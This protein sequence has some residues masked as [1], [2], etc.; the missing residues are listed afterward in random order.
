MHSFESSSLDFDLIVAATVDH[1]LV[2]FV[3]STPRPN[4]F[5]YSFCVA[6]HLN[7]PIVV[8]IARVVNAKEPVHLQVAVLHGAL[9]TD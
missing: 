3:F 5:E 4:V 9:L 8:T 7:P 2:N 1:F 6:F